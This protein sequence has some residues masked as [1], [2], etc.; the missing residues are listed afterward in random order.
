MAKYKVYAVGHGI[1][2]DTGEVVTDKI[3]N[4]WDECQ[5]YIKGASNVRYKGFLTT[6]EANEWLKQFN[7]NNIHNDSIVNELVVD[8][9]TNNN[10]IDDEFNNICNKLNINKD[11][12]I[13][14]LKKQFIETYNITSNK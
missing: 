1:N 13:E 7:A 2:P 14:L 12:V 4:T 3:C 10:S 11:N 5:K 6:A 9:N 8:N